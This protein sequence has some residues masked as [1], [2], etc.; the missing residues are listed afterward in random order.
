MNINFNR[1]KIESICILLSFTLV[2]I[3]TILG[4]L[5]TA[6][7]IFNW[8]LLPPNIENVMVLLLTSIAMVIGASFIISLMIN[9]SII[10]ISLE[11]FADKFEKF[12]EKDDR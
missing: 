10:S 8:D 1:R 6:D 11:K 2:I 4:I 5:A 3:I 7:E 12:V 9:F